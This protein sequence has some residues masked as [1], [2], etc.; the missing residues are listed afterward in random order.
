MIVAILVVL[1][2]ILGYFASETS[3]RID[4][5]YGGIASQTLHYISASL[6]A[7]LT[8]TVLT[9]IFI[10]DMRLLEIVGVIVVLSGLSIASAVLQAYFENPA[11]AAE[12]ARLAQRGW[13][14]EDARTSG[15]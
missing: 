9:S 11:R 5:L 4:P 1:G 12:L 2:V 7:I 15:L 8:P 10:L 14:E 6:M 13:T 3:K